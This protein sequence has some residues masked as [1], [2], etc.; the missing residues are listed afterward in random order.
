MLPAL[1]VNST[2]TSRCNAMLSL[3]SAA[4]PGSIGAGYRR[5]AGWQV[6]GPTDPDWLLIHRVPVGGR[7]MSRFRIR[8]IGTHGVRTDP[9]DLPDF[10]SLGNVHSFT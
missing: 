3:T 5:C 9:A 2:A 7:F 10:Q 4:P 1:S 6:L 8:T